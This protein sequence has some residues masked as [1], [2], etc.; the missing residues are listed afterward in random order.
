MT[1]VDSEIKGLLD[2]V[3]HY[4]IKYM[5]LKNQPPN[6]MYYLVNHVKVTQCSLQGLRPNSSITCNLEMQC[7]TPKRTE[8]LP[9]GTTTLMLMHKEKIQDISKQK[10]FL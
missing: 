7:S 6:Q 1:G 8:E 10:S 5:F 3:M 2:Y 9:E 4:I